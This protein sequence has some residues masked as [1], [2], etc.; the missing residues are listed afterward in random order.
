MAQ[1]YIG[2]IRPFAGNFAPAGWFFCDGSLQA[3]SDYE[4]LFDLIGTTYGGDGQNNF[5][6][7]D[8][9]GR[10]ILHNGNGFVMG[11][12]GGTE[13]ETLTTAQVPSH[14]HTVIATTTDA[15][16][17]SPAGAIPARPSAATIGYAYLKGTAAGT[18]APPAAAAISTI[19][20]GHPHS[21]MMAVTA[22]SYIISAFG[23]FPSQ[24]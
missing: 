13:Q 9:R 15:T 4:T 18:N 22:I 1:P 23:V 6:L 17:A 2:E 21:N 20:G 7:P 8:L 5:A 10:L 14:T 12:T 3:I 16:T 19:D 24:A 11:Q